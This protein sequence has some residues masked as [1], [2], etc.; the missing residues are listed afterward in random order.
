MGWS[1]PFL[2]ALP[3]ALAL[4]AVVAAAFALVSGTSGG[5]GTSADS[6]GVG[7]DS[8]GSVETSVDSVGAGVDPASAGTSVTSVGASVDS[9]GSVGAC[10]L[11]ADACV[12]FCV[13]GQG[14]AAAVLFGMDANGRVVLADAFGAASSVC[15][16]DERSGCLPTTRTAG[17][18]GRVGVALHSTKS[19]GV[20]GVASA[21]GVGAGEDSAAASASA[22]LSSTSMGCVSISMS[23]SRG[24]AS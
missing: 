11:F 3:F 18:G 23:S 9:V 24:C 15:T 16:V 19:P 12:E 7:V 6:I 21:G 20:L 13:S 17:G 5:D 8:E 2:A 10:V 4:G 14:V 1:P 22:W